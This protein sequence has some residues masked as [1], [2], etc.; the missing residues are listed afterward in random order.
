MI[1][2]T[3]VFAAL[4]TVIEEN[5]LGLRIHSQVPSTVNELP[6]G[7]LVPVSAD[8]IQAMGGSLTMMTVRLSIY[9]TSG[10]QQEASGRAQD[11]LAP[12]GAQSIVA[13]IDSDGTLD[14]NVVCAFVRTAD[15]VQREAFSGMD[16]T[17]AEF[18][19]EIWRN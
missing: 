15:A 13:A 12:T 4:K 3:D 6:A 2:T 17:V 8:P 9:T 10:L 5:V 1:T 19:I 18:T 14:G 7:I 11:Y 16:A